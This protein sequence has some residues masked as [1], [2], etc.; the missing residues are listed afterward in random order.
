MKLEGLDYLV[1]GDIT[2]YGKSLIE[3]HKQAPHLK[4][5]CLGDIID[6]GPNSK[7]ALDY[8]INNGF[9]SVMGNHDH[10]MWYEKHKNDP[11][12]SKKLY[13]FDCWVWNGGDVTLKDFGFPNL[14]SFD[15]SK[16]DQKYWDYIESMPLKIEV[17]NFVLTHA[18]IGMGNRNFFDFREINKDE[19]ILDRSALWNRMGPYA[20]KEGSIYKDKIQLYGHN[21]PKGVLWHTAKH[22]N[23]I[24]RDQFEPTD[25]PWAI[26]LD[27]W[28]AG[29]LSGLDLSTMK[30]YKQELID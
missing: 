24:Y 29:Y 13:P 5:I 9:K 17:E 11:E 28:R 23:G 22:L 4:I 27:T 18:P 19:M 25:P 1:V 20:A 30:I 15:A 2:G 3:L 6:R 8:L 16:V 26:C 7:L 10:F 12:V 21:S 14:A